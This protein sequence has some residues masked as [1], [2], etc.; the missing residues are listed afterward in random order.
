MFFSFK[1]IIFITVW[2][3]TRDTFWLL[4]NQFRQRK[5][6]WFLFFSCIS[7]LIF[8]SQLR[9]MW[10]EFEV[11]KVKFSQPWKFEPDKLTT[12]FKSLM[13]I[14]K[15]AVM[16]YLFSSGVS[17][18]W[19]SSNWYFKWWILCLKRMHQHDNT[20]RLLNVMFSTVILCLQLFILSRDSIL[21]FWSLIIHVIK[22]HWNI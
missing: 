5:R 16:Q 22:C 9:C 2:V 10:Y 7:V 4:S 3:V 15:F 18:F 20:Q 12:F 13:A 14:K 6:L 8:V 19:L 21:F 17:D 1:W 11:D